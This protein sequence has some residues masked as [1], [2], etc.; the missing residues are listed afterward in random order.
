MYFMVDE[1]S[2]L[3]LGEDFSGTRWWFETGRGGERKEGRWRFGE[4]GGEREA[5]LGKPGGRK[6]GEAY[7]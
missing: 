7:R 5:W 3:L 4:G 1:P 2:R 6:L